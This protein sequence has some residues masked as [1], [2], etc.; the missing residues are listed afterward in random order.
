M[1]FYF[2][3]SFFVNTSLGNA[4]STAI[5]Q[6]VPNNLFF[7]ATHLQKESQIG[8]FLLRMLKLFEKIGYDLQRKRFAER[9][10][11][12]GALGVLLPILSELLKHPYVEKR[13]KG[14][15]GSG[16]KG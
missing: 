1:V 8:D 14:Q 5:H 11:V 16:N 3:D 12:V 9:V 6:T 4:R 10:G 13:S 2:F 7:I 15:M